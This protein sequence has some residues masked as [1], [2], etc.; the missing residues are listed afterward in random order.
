MGHF[1]AQGKSVLVT[2]QTQKALSVLKEKVAP[3]LQNLCVSVLDDS[4]V[5]MEKS[6]DGIT[7]YMAQTTSFEVKR[8]ME[9]LCQ[10]RKEIISELAAVRKKLFAIINQECNCIV[11]N[12]EETSPSAA[13]AYVQENSESL[14]YIPGSVQLYEPLP[15]SFTELTELYRSNNTISAQDEAEFEHDIPD[16]AELMSPEEFEQKCNALDFARARLNTI[17]ENNHWQIQNL[18]AEHKIL[19]DGTFGQFVVEYPSAQAVEQ[20]K[21]YVSTFS[22]IEPW[23]QYCA[24]DGRKGG[25]YKELWTRLIE[26]IETTCAYAEKLVAK[27]FGKEIVILNAEPEFYNAMHQ[28]QDKYSQGGKIGKLALFLNKQLEVALN[29]ATINGQKPQNAEDCNLILCVLE[30]KSMREQCASYWND[31]IAKHGVPMFQ[32]LDRDDPERVAANYIPLIQRYLEWFSNEY[33]VL[34]M[35]MAEVGLPF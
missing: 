23:M 12:G 30:M 17:S 18:V 6:I 11:Y 14:S 31:L 4:N 2:S 22:K 20:L 7:S 16:P 10:E 5:D 25:T 29:G 8:E 19:V 24:V 27:K 13:A 15:L 21:Q 1:L 35:R 9:A 28:L 26:Q 33:E 34:T 3:G 32:E